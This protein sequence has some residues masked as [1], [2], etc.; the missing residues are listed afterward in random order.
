VQYD[1]TPEQY[2]SLTRLIA[3]LSTALPKIT[4]DYTRDE[5]GNLILTN[6]NREQFANYQGVLGHYHVQAN[7]QDPGPA[8]QWDRIITDAR[9]LMSKEAIRRMEAERGK[10]VREVDRPRRSTTRPTT[11]PS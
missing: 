4:V 7:K 8:M 11:R 5:Q 3:A 10:P 9:K 2:D 1:Y 6:L